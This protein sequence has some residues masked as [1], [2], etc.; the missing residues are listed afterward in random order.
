MLSLYIP[1][2]GPEGLPKNKLVRGKPIS[3]QVGY[4]FFF[5]CLKCNSFIKNSSS[6]KKKKKQKKK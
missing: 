1:E 6:L 3:A 2:V 5:F 4:F